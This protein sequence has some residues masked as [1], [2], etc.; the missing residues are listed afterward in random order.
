V[1]RL[2]FEQLRLLHG[3]WRGRGRGQYPTIDP[4]DYDEETR[5]EFDDRYPLI[6]FEQRTILGN[7]EPGHWESG[8]VRVADDGTVEIS[9]AQDGGRVEVIRGPL[10]VAGSGFRLDLESVALGHDERLLRTGRVLELSGDRLRYEM[11]MST[12][13]TDAPQW[14]THLTAELRRES[15]EG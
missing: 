7:G 13:T 2:S 12:R 6:H 15:G 5:F 9:T 3:V 14:L 11:K 10:A 8:F 4:F 1:E